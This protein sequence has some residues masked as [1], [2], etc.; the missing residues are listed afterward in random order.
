MMRI[1]LELR[2]DEASVAFLDQLERIQVRLDAVT[3]GPSE[4]WIKLTL[5]DHEVN[6]RVRYVERDGRNLVYKPGRQVAP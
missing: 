1:M 4:D 3:T 6:V 2:D 5:L